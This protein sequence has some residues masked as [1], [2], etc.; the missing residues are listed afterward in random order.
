MKTLIHY[1]MDKFTVSLANYL[2][3][4]VFANTSN[5]LYKLHFIHNFDVCF[6][7]VNDDISREINNFILEFQSKKKIFLYYT[8]P[9]AQDYSTIFKHV[10]H[11]SRNGIKL[12][13]K[14]IE[15]PEYF[16]NEKLFI[17]NSTEQRIEKYCVFLG[18]SKDIPEKLQSI[19][20]PN[21]TIPINMF[22]SPYIKHCQNMGMISEIEKAK[23][24]QTYKYFINIDNSYAHEAKICGCQL[25]EITKDN[26]LQNNDIETNATPIKTIVKD[27]GL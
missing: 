7:S 24:L 14:H 17:K 18:L 19:L 8:N 15:L 26:T 13:G 22:E 25:A 21:T 12:S 1:D 10:T 27:M 20:Y 2:E 5:V 11:I 3:S 16:F 23:I 6:F 4:S 9:S